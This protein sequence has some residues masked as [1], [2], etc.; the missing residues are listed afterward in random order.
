MTRDPLS[1]YVYT[2]CSHTL[3][4]HPHAHPHSVK[5]LGLLTVVLDHDARAANDLARLALGVDLAQT[6]PLAELLGA[7]NRDEVDVVLLAQRLHELG[8]EGER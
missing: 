1:C 5:P 2:A 8:G 7:G 3:T 6:S 4:A